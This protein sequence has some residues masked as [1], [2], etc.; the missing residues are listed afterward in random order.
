MCALGDIFQAKL[1]KILGD[2][3]G[4]KR[5]IDDI[6]VL[7]KDFF[8]KHLDQPRIIFGSLSAAGLKFNAP[9]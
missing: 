4:V 2:I 5:Y 7:S 9:K 6:L 8:K 1:D 3:E